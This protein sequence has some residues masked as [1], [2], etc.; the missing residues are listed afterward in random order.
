MTK[1]SAAADGDV[2]HSVDVGFVVLLFV[3]VELTDTTIVEVF[4][5]GG[6]TGDGDADAVEEDVDCVLFLAGSKSGG[7][8][9]QQT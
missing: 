6:S 2:V 3:V 1:R 8:L 5:R 9:S 7:Y 4:T